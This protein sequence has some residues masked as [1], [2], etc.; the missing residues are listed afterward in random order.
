VRAAAARALGQLNPLP[1]D[2]LNTLVKVAKADSKNPVRLAA[3]R[4]L[5]TAG[6]RAKPARAEIEALTTNP[7]PGLAAW[8]KVTLAA[9]DG[10]VSK[11]APSV[12]AGLTDRNPTVR[13]SSAEALLLVGPAQGDLPAILKLLKDASST[14]RTA[15][16]TAAGRLGPFAKEAVPQ[17]T[18][19]LDDRDAEVRVAAAEALGHIGPASLPAVAKLKELR[20]DPVVKT[21]AEKALERIGAK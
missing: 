2:A 13:A 19:Q 11:A 14:T 18:R 17:L 8:A 15:A 1:P 5:A 9:V 7:Q 16:A 4:A 6:P 20:A 10:D 21:T 3:Y 12:R